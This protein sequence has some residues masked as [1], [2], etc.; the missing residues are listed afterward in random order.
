M[1]IKLDWEIESAQARTR[2]TGGEDPEA[3]RYRRNLRWRFLALVFVLALLIGGVGWFLQHRLNEVNQQLRQQ[4]VD[5]VSAEAAALRLGDLRAFL[6]LQHTDNNDWETAQLASFEAYQQLKISNTLDLTGNVDAVEFDRNYQRARAQVREVIDGVP[7]QVLWFYWYFE[8]RGWVHVAP[9]Y[10]F[11]GDEITYSGTH[12]SVRYRAVDDAFAQAVGLQV[13]GW[14]S[15]ACAW[16]TCTT[17]LT[18]NVVVDP[19]L[20]PSWSIDGAQLLIPSPYTGRARVD[21][22][23]NGDLQRTVATLIAERFIDQALVGR[24]PVY[25]AD[26]FYLRQAVIS[27][28]VGRFLG[29]ETNAH[30]IESLAQAYGDAAVL[31]LLQTLQP[32]SDGRVLAQAAD[33]A[34]LDQALLDWRDFLTWRLLLED[35]LI[36]RRDDTNYIQLFD[37]R[38]DTVRNTAYQRFSDMAQAGRRV[39]VSAEPVVMTDGTTVLRATVQNT[40]TGV[41]EE[42]FFTLVDGI[43]KRAS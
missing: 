7:Y 27:W 5:T 24:E 43:W 32:I 36:L 1:G 35:D 33:V 3:A 42:I 13:E 6:A 41:T 23:F 20:K 38:I 9:D 30:I 15:Q 4:L 25:P 10:T 34:S 22:P 19:L 8:G 12:M 39:V 28:L 31:R 14:F 11:W 40:T 2:N 21:A 16:F 29:V 26:A 37:T 18:M 17:P